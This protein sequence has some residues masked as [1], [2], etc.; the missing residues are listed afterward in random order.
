M[1]KVPFKTSKKFKFLHSVF[2]ESVTEINL[3]KER[4]TRAN[5]ATITVIKHYKT[6]LLS[7]ILMVKALTS[8]IDSHLI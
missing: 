2:K 1:L 4:S 3:S 8:H 7:D 5:F 6:W